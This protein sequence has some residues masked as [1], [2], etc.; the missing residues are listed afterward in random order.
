MEV[1]ESR[2]R[3]LLKVLLVVAV[4][5]VLIPAVLQVLA[6]ADQQLGSTTYSATVTS[7]PSQSD[8]SDA[9]QVTFRLQGS[10]RTG[11]VL[12]KDMYSAA[13]NVSVVFHPAFLWEPSYWQLKTPGN[14]TA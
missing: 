12:A 7:L 13:Q 2:T 5:L 4:A 8:C 3:A 11:S 1:Q 14:C 9:H 6:D 10:D